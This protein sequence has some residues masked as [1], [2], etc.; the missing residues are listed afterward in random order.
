MQL[1]GEDNK[2]EEFIEEII[3]GQSQRQ[4]YYKCFPQSYNWKVETVDEKA[5]KLWNSA[6]VRARYNEILDKSK[7]KTI[8]TREEL[9]RGLVKGFRMAIGEEYSE[10]EVIQYLTD[11]EGN[12]KEQKKKAKL[13]S[14]DL[15]SLKGIA[16]T[17]AKMEG[18]ITE[19]VEHSGN[20]N[21]KTTVAKIE[22]YE[23][24]FKGER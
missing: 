5:C 17:I 20:L 3:K 18:Y 24:L 4:A 19:K 11:A 22:E 21:I 8:I 14:S 16:E 15:K 12:E 1:R 10:E 6:K 9:L 7:E 23:E 13:K 2:I